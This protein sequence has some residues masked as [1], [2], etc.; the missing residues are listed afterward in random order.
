[1]ETPAK[2]W[3]AEYAKSARSRC[4][5]CR[6]SILYERFRLGKVKPAPQFDGLITVTFSALSFSNFLHALTAQ[7]SSM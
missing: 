4:K 3:K 5:K 6:K 2:T 1:M 7:I